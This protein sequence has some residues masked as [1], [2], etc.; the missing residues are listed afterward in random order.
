MS[1][2]LLDGLWDVKRVPALAVMA[3]EYF[4]ASG[5]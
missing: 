2:Q 5:L 1:D 4:P 3:W